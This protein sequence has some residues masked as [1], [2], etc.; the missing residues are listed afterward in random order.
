MSIVVNLSNK[1]E[2]IA[3]LS[4]SG[5]ALNFEPNKDELCLANTLEE[6]GDAL[7]HL[8]GFFSIV[9]RSENRLYAAVDHVRSIPLFYAYSQGKFFLSDSAEWVRLQ[10][11]EHEYSPIAKEEFLLAGYVTGRDTLFHKVKQLLPGEAIMFDGLEGEGSLNL[12]RYFKLTHKEPEH[13]EE[14]DLNQKLK[15]IV[16]KSINRLIKY[17]DGRQIVVPLSSGYDSRLIVSYLKKL[18][19]DNVLTFSYGV[20]GNLESKNS[21]RVAHSLGLKW[22]FV[23]YSAEKWLEAW[24]SNE[25]NEYKRFASNHV[26]LPHVQDWLAISELTKNNI[27][28][29]DAVVVPGHAGDFIGGGHIPSYIF[30]NRSH[31]VA[32]II[33]TII[34]DHL[35]NAPIHGFEH[36]DKEKLIRRVTSNFERTGILKEN[37]SS[38]EAADLYEMWDWQERQSKYIV[39]SVRVYEQFGLHWWL[40]LWDRELVEFWENAPLSIRRER[41]WF[42]FWIKSEYES[43]CLFNDDQLVNVGDRTQIFL[44]VKKIFLLFPEYFTK[45]VK[46]RRLKKSLKNHPLGFHGIAGNLDISKYVDK[47]YDIIGIY[48]KLYIDQEW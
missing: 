29:S 27:V 39:N 47:G 8:N 20:A 35:S 23:E 22:A 43:V 33:D 44:F 1:W 42:K 4:L 21:K 10:V 12:R 13:F 24:S 14:C 17:A 30:K 18:K 41:E 9:K 25:A 7:K 2:E 15:L 26:S 6:W 31:Q 37:L 11:N 46:Q 3:C 19:Y 36:L 16:E 48:S 32:K 5:T 28:N 34:D 38:C 45:K 40:P